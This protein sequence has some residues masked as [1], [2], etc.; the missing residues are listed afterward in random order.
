MLWAGQ[1]KYWGTIEEATKTW[2][3]LGMDIV[4]IKITDELPLVGQD[5]NLVNENFEKLAALQKEYGVKYH[6]HPFDIMVNHDLLTLSTPEER[7]IT[8][9]ILQ[10]LDSRII[11]YEFYPLITFHL[12][13]FKRP[14]FNI[15]TD[16]KSVLEQSVDFY[17]DLNLKTPIALETMHDPLRNGESGNSILGY[18]PEHFAQVI[19][20][21]N[22]YLGLCIDT[23]HNNLSAQSTSKYL[24]L[25]YKILS[26]HLHGNDRRS[27]KHKLPNYLSVRDYNSTLEALR[28]CEGPVVLEL[29]EN[30]TREQIKRCMKY[31]EDSVDSTS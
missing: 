16:E 29:A 4:M 19:G 24:E 13:F 9:D 12:P 2:K 17:Y 15:D 23:G 18:K 7:K 31:W 11:I 25:P 28:R 21:N 1:N 3:E 20:E 22:S 14:R 8:K 27:D 10:D 5:G 26:V 6:L 30:P